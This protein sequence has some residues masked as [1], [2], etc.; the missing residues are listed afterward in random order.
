MAA[1]WR[2]IHCQLILRCE[3]DPNPQAKTIGTTPNID[4]NI[5]Y[6]TSHTTRQL[7]LRMGFCLP[8]D[9]SDRSTGMTT[10]EIHLPDVHFEAPVTE[11]ISRENPGE[12]TPIISNRLRSD[13]IAVCDLL[14]PKLH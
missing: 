13:H 9:A 11:L 7:C 2:H 3:L 10:R 4:T 8:V 6:S 5:E 14:R 12:R 1:T